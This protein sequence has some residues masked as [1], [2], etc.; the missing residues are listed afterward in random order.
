MSSRTRNWIRKWFTREMPLEEDSPLTAS[1]ERYQNGVI[2]IHISNCFENGLICSS[3]LEIVN[4]FKSR[5]EYDMDGTGIY[6]LVRGEPVMYD[7]YV[8]LEIDTY[9][10]TG[11]TIFYT[12]VIRNQEAFEWLHFK[13]LFFV[14]EEEYI[15]RN[16][17]RQ[18]TMDGDVLK[19]THPIIQ[20]GHRHKELLSYGGRMASEGF[21]A[22]EITLKLYDVNTLF[23]APPL[24]SGDVERIIKS[25]IKYI[26]ER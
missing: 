13:Y 16:Y 6:I 10:L 26:E 21:S 9:Y 14:Q 20:T 19:I 1:F 22:H 8:G 5:T 11:E 2:G 7:G 4:H 25:V 18:I 23:C 12:K 17:F 15:S 3:A 24:P